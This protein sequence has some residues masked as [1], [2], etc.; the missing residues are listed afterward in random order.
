MNKIT[1]KIIF[2][3]N[4]EIRNTFKQNNNVYCTKLKG[5]F[6]QEKHNPEILIISRRANCQKPED[7][8]IIKIILPILYAFWISNWISNYQP[9]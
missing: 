4:K 8:I 9:G 3:I 7:Y 6:K 5:L 1:K 2:K